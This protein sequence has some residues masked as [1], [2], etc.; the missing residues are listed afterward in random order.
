MHLR[1]DVQRKEAASSADQA[2]AKTV[3]NDAIKQL[4]NSALAP[5]VLDRAFSELTFEI[6]DQQ[7]ALVVV[8][9]QRQRQAEAEEVRDVV[10][11]EGHELL[12][13][14]RDVG[15][16]VGQLSTGEVGEAVVAGVAA[17]RQEAAGGL[18]GAP[19]TV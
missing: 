11:V 14:E 6:G 12:G 10:A 16:D 4:T 17:V 7:V 1:P 5:A 2:Q 13:S 8:D 9:R 3:S 18:A 15:G 19:M